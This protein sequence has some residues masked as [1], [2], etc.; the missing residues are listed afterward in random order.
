LLESCRAR[1]TVARG[2]PAVARRK[3]KVVV[4]DDFTLLKSIA[5][6]RTAVTQLKEDL[7][8]LK[9][10]LGEIRSDLVNLM[11]RLDHVRR[12]VDGIRDDLVDHHNMMVS[13]HRRPGLLKRIKHLLIRRLYDRDGG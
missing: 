6:L 10:S 5:S 12:T 2:D 3:K 1:A 8:D 11:V 4:E 9:R 7:D 13:L